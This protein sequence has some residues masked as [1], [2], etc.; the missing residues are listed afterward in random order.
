MES[1]EIK[2]ICC[3]LLT[4][5]VVSVMQFNIS[6]RLTIGMVKRGGVE[7]HYL[8]DQSSSASRSRSAIGAAANT[9]PVVALP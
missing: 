4:M 6:E 7:T 1:S 8:L 5:K 9:F 3:P 2:G